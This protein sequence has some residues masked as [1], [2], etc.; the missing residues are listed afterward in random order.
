MAPT[1]KEFFK[2]LQLFYRQVSLTEEEISQL[3]TA[4]F[5][6]L[7]EK[8]YVT[9]DFLGYLDGQH[10]SYSHYHITDAGKVYYV[11]HSKTEWFKQNWIA[12]LGMVF[13]FISAIPV[14][15]QAIACILNRIM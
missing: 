6:Q 13:A 14:I 8:E 11:S 15:L 7:L 4:A 9:R 5:S 12:L 3:P 1:D 2:T 10:R